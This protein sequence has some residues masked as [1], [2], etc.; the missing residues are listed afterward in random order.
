M[1]GWRISVGQA[2]VF[3]G[4]PKSTISDKILNKFHLINVHS[5]VPLAPN[6]IMSDNTICSVLNLVQ[7]PINTFCIKICLECNYWVALFIKTLFHTILEHWSLISVIGQ[8]L[9]CLCKQL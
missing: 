3:Y 5:N 4:V 1:V 7:C 9:Y 6:T 8:V 2:T